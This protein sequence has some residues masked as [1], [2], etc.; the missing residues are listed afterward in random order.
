MSMLERMLRY[1][2]R[3]LRALERAP[4]TLGIAVFTLSLLAFGTI[5][6]FRGESLAL[7]QQLSEYRDKLDGASPDEAKAALDVLTDE[8]TALQARLKPRRVDARQRQVILDR[9]KIPTG[10]RYALAIVHEGGCWDCPQYAADFDDTFRNIPGVLVSKRVAMGL[11]QRPPRGLAVIVSD[12]GHPSAQE[13]VLLQALQG[14]GIDF[15]VQGARAPL[16]PG[17][18]LLL[19]AKAPQ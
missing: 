12:P 11:A 14:A 16:D 10:T 3:E 2:A 19:A 5:W 1:W 6:K 17:V 7:R 18:Q 15:D 9:L 13:T 4:A 8:V